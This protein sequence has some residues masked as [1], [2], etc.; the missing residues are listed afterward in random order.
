MGQTTP[1]TPLGKGTK[2]GVSRSSLSRQPPSWFMP[3]SRDTRVPQRETGQR[4]NTAPLPTSPIL[5]I[6]APTFPAIEDAKRKKNARQTRKL[7]S[8]LP[9]PFPTTQP[10]PLGP[11]PSPPTHKAPAQGG[12]LEECEKGAAWG[13]IPLTNREQPNKVRRQISGESTCC[14]TE[15]SVENSQTK[16]LARF[17]GNPLA[18]F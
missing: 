9:P 3:H 4:V 17:P 11:T 1:R 8:S 6:S 13:Q 2:P 14:L 12:L 16:S 18:V 5:P 7:P 15:S 10:P